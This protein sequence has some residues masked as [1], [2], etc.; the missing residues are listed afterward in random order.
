MAEYLSTGLRD[1]VLEAGGSSLADA[2]ADGVIYIYAGTPPTD[3]DAVADVASA[4]PLLAT[5][6]LASGAF[7]H[8]VST[9]GI[10]LAVSTAGVLAKAVAEVWSGVCTTGGTASWFRYCDNDGNT[11][12]PHAASTTAVRIQG[13]IATSGAEINMSNRVLVLAG[14]TTI[15]GFNVTLPAS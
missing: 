3:A 14:T 8:G 6:T 7:T 1:A 5:I 10:N 11:D 13:A 15:D 2:L 12:A 9:N 4:H